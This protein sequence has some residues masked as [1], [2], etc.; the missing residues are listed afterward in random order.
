MSRLRYK[1]DNTFLSRGKLKLNPRVE[2]C[3]GSPRITNGWTCLILRFAS[4]DVAS[5]TLSFSFVCFRSPTYFCCRRYCEECAP[6]INLF[7]H[8][9]RIFLV[10]SVIFLRFASRQRKQNVLFIVVIEP[11]NNFIKYDLFI[12][13]EF[14]FW[15][16]IPGLIDKPTIQNW[17]SALLVLVMWMCL[18]ASIE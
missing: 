18:L 12:P 4:R 16:V 3:I 17:F 15:V 10:L 11:T 9:A 8:V 6:K 7:W 14:L 1:H 5:W 2:I 13:H